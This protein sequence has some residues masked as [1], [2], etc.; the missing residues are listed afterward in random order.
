ML[1]LTF[2]VVRCDFPFQVRGNL[3]DIRLA[4]SWCAAIWLS[5][6][7]VIDGDRFELSCFGIDCGVYVAVE[8]AV[9]RVEVLAGEVRLQHS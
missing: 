5:L 1:F 8:G 4:V 9:E 2:K 6:E 7:W 3:M